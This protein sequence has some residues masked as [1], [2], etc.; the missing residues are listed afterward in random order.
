M[1][2][3]FDSEDPD[4]DDREYDKWAAHAQART[5]TALFA[6]ESAR[7][8]G[9]AGM[10]AVAVHPGVVK[11]DLQRCLDHLEE[12]TV[13]AMSTAEGEV[14]SPEAGAASIVWA[15]TAELTSTRVTSDDG[16]RARDGGRSR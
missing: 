6:V 15:A 3:G 8:Y 13:M 9:D 2:G 14:R 1:L 5:A 12:Q 10:T 7:R 16:R 11:T 4:F